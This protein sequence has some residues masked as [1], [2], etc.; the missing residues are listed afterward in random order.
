MESEL[1]VGQAYVAAKNYEA[2]FN[3]FHS[4]GKVLLLLLLL[5]EKI[6]IYF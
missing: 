4:L 2:A 6:K 5:L 3:I 1:E